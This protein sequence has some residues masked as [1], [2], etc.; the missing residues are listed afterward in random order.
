MKIKILTQVDKGCTS[1]YLHSGVTIIVRVI[2]W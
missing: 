2:A 1:P